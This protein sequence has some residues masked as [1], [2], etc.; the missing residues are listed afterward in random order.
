LLSHKKELEVILDKKVTKKLREE[1]LN[2]NGID[3]AALKKKKAKSKNKKRK[4][5]KKR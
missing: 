1:Q 2:A 5:H 4:K 3:V